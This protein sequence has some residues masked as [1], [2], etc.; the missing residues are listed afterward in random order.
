MKGGW[1]YSFREEYRVVTS[2][3][4]ESAVTT[5]TKEKQPP[6]ILVDLVGYLL[7]E[8]MIRMEMERMS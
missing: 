7:F 3:D 1:N 8:V 4:Y 6:A 5:T 2:D